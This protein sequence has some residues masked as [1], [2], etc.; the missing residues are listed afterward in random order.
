MRRA[1]EEA[2]NSRAYKTAGNEIFNVVC[3]FI[4]SKSRY[5]IPRQI[6][7]GSTGKNTALGNNFEPDFDVV[8][9][10]KDVSHLQTLKPIADEFY[11]ILRNLPLS[12]DGYWSRFEMQPRL[13]IGTH[14]C[15]VQFRMHTTIQ[16]P[17]GKKV[18][19]IDFDLLP[20]YDLIPS[21]ERSNN[22]EVQKQVALQKIQASGDR[23]EASYKYS[24]SMSESTVPFV[25]NQPDFVHHVI[26][27]AKLW[28]KK[29][30]ADQIRVRGNGAYISG[31]SAI[32]E[33][34]AIKTAR[35]AGG[36]I[37]EA[38]RG[39]LN[40]MASIDRMDVDFSNG[41]IRHSFPRI[42]DGVNPYYN[43]GTELKPQHIADFKTRAAETLDAI[44]RIEVSGDYNFAWESF[45][46]NYLASA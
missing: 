12:Y 17:T 30:K 3:N 24:S 22:F 40:A 14:A 8:L 4:K 29:L 5:S 28:D 33:L 41:S 23:E 25:N 43:F 32:I 44:K 27:L 18:V 20:A 26:R 36:S 15:G 10:V 9:F 7:A 13:N 21:Y 42:I 45:K 6:I 1:A 2:E 37:L 35:D 38:F 34:V 39:F 46:A 11:N 31:R 19:K 16:L